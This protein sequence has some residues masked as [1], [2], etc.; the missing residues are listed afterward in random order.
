M[1]DS[2]ILVQNIIFW[3]TMPR[4]GVVWSTMLGTVTTRSTMLRTVLV[5]S[6]SPGMAWSTMLQDNYG[7]VNHAQYRD[8]LA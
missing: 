4:T 8:G 5:S 3:Y 7:L 2:D 1:P 6:D